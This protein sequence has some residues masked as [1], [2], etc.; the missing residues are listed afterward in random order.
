MVFFRVDSNKTI[1][2][3]H[4]LRCIAIAQCFRDAGVKV[5]FITADNNATPTLESKGFSVKCLYSHWDN[6]EYEVKQMQ[7]L[8][9]QN[10]GS[11]L[12]ID[13]Y[14]VTTE[15][16]KALMPFANICYLGSKRIA[17]GKI[18]A[19]INY[20]SCINYQFYHQAYSENTKQLLGVSYAPLRKEFQE[21]SYCMQ[22]QLSGVLITTGA[23]NPNKFVEKILMRFEQNCILKKLQVNVVIGSMFPNVDTLKREYQKNDLFCFHD[24]IVSMSQ[25][26][27]QNDLAISANGTTVYELAACGVPTISFAMS[28]EQVESARGLFELGTVDYCGEMF[29]NENTCIDKIIERI[30]Y[31]ISHDEA[32]TRL[33]QKAKRLIDGNGCQR[34]VEQL[35]EFLK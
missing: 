17:L 12:I 22:S 7:D 15:Y 35:R 24:N 31:Y 18:Q 27:R 2:S 14:S 8:L 5:C 34:I 4:V 23:T 28:Q 29:K 6:L 19:V 25:L 32:R 3:G 1:A 33:S 16:T 30:L 26:M 10:Y 20:S 9:V 21:I 11:L 13:T